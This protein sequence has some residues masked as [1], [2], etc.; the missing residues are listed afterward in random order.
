MATEY[1]ALNLGQGFPDFPVS[2]ELIDRIYINM[3]AIYS[4]WKEK[5]KT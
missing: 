3:K 4:P 1:G 5:Q 2:E